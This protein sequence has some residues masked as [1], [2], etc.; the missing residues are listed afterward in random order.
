ME[1]MNPSVPIPPNHFD[2]GK[3]FYPFVV[4]Y[5]AMLF[6]LK[7]LAGR[8]LALRSRAEHAK[9]LADL[10]AAERGSSTDEVERLR[11]EL[12]NYLTPEMGRFIS[13][14]PN[15]SNCFHP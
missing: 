9:C 2:R 12:S 7:E 15:Q 11:T 13:W 8:G 5:V 14:L 3:P 4:N 6:G 10:R 1:T